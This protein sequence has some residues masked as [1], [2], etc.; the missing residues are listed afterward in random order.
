MRK[1]A[2]NEKRFILSFHN[3]LSQQ[4]HSA[5]TGLGVFTLGKLN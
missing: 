5:L 1:T 2:A 4:G 3:A